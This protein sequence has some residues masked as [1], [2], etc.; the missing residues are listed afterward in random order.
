MMNAAFAAAAVKSGMY[1]RILVSGVD[2]VGNYCTVMI[3]RA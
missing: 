3:E 1:G 2:M